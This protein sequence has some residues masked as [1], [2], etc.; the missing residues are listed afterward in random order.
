M[1]KVEWK[2]PLKFLSTIARDMLYIVSVFWPCFIFLVS[3]RDSKHDKRM[4]APHEIAFFLD[5]RMFSH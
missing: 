5:Q 4:L 3:F 2:L 1:Y